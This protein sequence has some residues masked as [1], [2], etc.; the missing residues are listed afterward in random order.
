MLA[1]AL[2]L[3]QPLVELAKELQDVGLSNAQRYDRLV[4]FLNRPAPAS[5]LSTRER[6]VARLTAALVFEEPEP[7]RDAIAHALGN[8]L[9]GVEIGL[10]SASVAGLRA[11][12]AAVSAAAARRSCC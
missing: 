8:G 10:V 6:A 9:S 4:E 7:M 1:L 2:R 3:R 11:V 12:P 5:L